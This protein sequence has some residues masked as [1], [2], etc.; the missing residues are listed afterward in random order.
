MMQITTAAEFQKVLDHG[1]Y[2]WPG[3]YP[4]FFITKDG[5][6]M[7]FEA[8]RDNVSRIKMALRYKDDADWEPIAV[9][10]NWEDEHLLCCVRNRLIPSAYGDDL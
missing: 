10:V 7:S 8:A 1:P 5:E 2:A 9:G 3:G 4:L 6:A